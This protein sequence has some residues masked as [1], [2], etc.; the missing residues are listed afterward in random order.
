[1]T[2]KHEQKREGG[3]AAFKQEEKVMVIPLAKESRKSSRNMRKNRSVREIK[4]FLSRHMRTVPS[5][6]FISQQLNEFLW[7][8]G[9][10]NTPAKIKVRVSTG[11]D[12]KVFAR[13]L[14]EKDRARK[15]IRKKQGLMNRLARRREGAAP[16]EKTEPKKDAPPQKPEEKPAP[17]EK[18]PEPMKETPQEEAKQDILPGH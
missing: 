7:K 8:G 1:M 18:K 12:G 16:V 5:N 3:S 4:A 2:E 11:E 14:D 10:H 13:L 9:I 17:A 15:E 6:V